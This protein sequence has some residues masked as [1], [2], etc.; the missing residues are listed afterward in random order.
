MRLL[1]AETEII[2]SILADEKLLVQ[3]MENLKDS[4]FGGQER[5]AFVGI[6]DA[7]EKYGFNGIWENAGFRSDDIVQYVRYG[8]SSLDE[9]I[10]VVKEM[11]VRRDIL[12]IIS[13]LSIDIREGA[14]PASTALEAVN[15]ISDLIN[16][17]STKRE[18]TMSEVMMEAVSTIEA[19][20]NGDA[21]W[22]MRTGLAIDAKIGG[23]QNGLFYIIAARPSM[24]KTA[25][26]LQVAATLAKQTPGAFLSLE[27]TNRNIGFRHIIREAMIDGESLREGNISEEQFAVIM[28]KASE[29]SNLS[30]ITD[31]TTDV[32]AGGIYAKA[33]YFKRKHNIGFL[34]IDYVQL[35]KSDKNN[36]EQQI[37]D[38]SRA[39]ALTAKELDI[40]VIGL[41][42]LSRQNE[43]R[44]DRRPLLSD[45]RESGQL[46]QDAYCVVFLHRPEYYSS[47]PYPD[48]SSTANIC[49][50]IVAKNKDGPTGIQ[51]MH[52]NKKHMRFENLPTN[53]GLG[54]NHPVHKKLT[55]TS[56]V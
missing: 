36:R 45:L 37:A 10:R 44:S 15:A 39:C 54:G 56:H 2:G 33:N 46:E 42:Q 28:E 20:R 9:N 53:P 4:D 29:L 21:D 5:D 31:D 47:E 51:K 25:F 11:S 52:F 23:F 34:F 7:Y 48:G 35:M 16:S 38:V 13:K 3:V 55:G 24:G 8:I 30:L 32:S 43:Q 22:G 1:Q 14:D 27:T 18:L 26:A 6:K 41:A 49:E 12:T 17:S 50:C 19:L 40:P